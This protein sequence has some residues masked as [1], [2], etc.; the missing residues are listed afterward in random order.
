MIA[1][2]SI[3]QRRPFLPSN[4]S[5]ALFPA[6]TNSCSLL[7]KFAEQKPVG[8]ASK[9]KIRANPRVEEIEK[10]FKNLLRNLDPDESFLLNG[11]ETV[12]FAK[13]LKFTPEEIEEFSLKLSGCTSEWALQNIGVFLSVLINNSNGRKFTIHTHGALKPIP[14][15]CYRNRKEVIV[16]GDAGLGA[17]TFM[18]RGKV[19]IN[20]DVGLWLGDTMDSG[21][22]YVNGN[23]NPTGFEVGRDDG[24]KVE[25]WQNGNPIIQGGK[26][27]SVPENK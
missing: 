19:T 27:V 24:D 1:E 5:V 3:Q 7:D 17:C 23:I 16:Q 4:M 8:K 13:G 11:P 15:L 21:K 18:A 10:A 9:Q 26:V 12:K 20:G 14:Y 22:I 25:I 6:R 2:T